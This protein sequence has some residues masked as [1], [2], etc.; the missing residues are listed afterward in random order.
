MLTYVKSPHSLPQIAFAECSGVHVL[1]ISLLYGKP[2]NSGENLNGTVHPAGG[3]FAEKKECLSRYHLFPVFNEKD[4]N[5]SVPFVWITS[6]RLYVE[7]KRKIYRYFVTGTTQSRSCFRCQK[8]YQYH[9]TKIFHRN[10]RTNGKR[11][12][13][14]DLISKKT[15]LRLA[16]FFCLS[17]PLFCMTIMPFCRNVKLPSYKLFL[18]RNCRMCY[19]RV[20]FLCS[21]LLLFFHC[22]SF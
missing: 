17:L 14:I 4:R 22:H 16:H 12:R 20:C 15:N 6:A 11:L 18:W 21:C 13:S 19:Q 9:I 10:F 8:K 5:F 3:N 1:C 2:G 7:T